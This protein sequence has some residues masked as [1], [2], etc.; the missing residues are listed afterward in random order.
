MALRMESW[1]WPGGVVVK[2]MCST[3]AT[4]GMHSWISGGDLVPL[5]KP[6]HSGIPYKIQEDFSSV[7]VFLRQ[8]EEDWQ[9][10]LAQGKSPLQKK[11]E[12]NS[13]PN[14]TFPLF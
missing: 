13:F 11:K 6:R 12:W 10:T 3:L 7:T 1:G 4:W 2:F 5:V 14:G 8:K 9:Q